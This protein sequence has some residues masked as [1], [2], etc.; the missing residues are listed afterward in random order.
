M[1]DRDSNCCFVIFV[2]VVVATATVVTGTRLQDGD[3]CSVFSL[4]NLHSFQMMSAPGWLICV[5][6]HTLIPICKELLHPGTPKK[7]ATKWLPPSHLGGFIAGSP[8]SRF[9]RGQGHRNDQTCWQLLRQ[10]QQLGRPFDAPD[11]AVET[12]QGV[13]N[14]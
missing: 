13:S 4:H 8:G 1:K 14:R 3:G 12:E 6:D 10:L 9:C 2:Q 7:M 5:G 11:I